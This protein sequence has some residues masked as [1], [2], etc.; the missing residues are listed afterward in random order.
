MQSIPATAPVDMVMPQTP[1]LVINIIS[2]AIVAVFLVMAI[3]HYRREG[4][5]IGIW[6]LLGGAFSVFNEPI[7]DVLGK[8]WFPAIDSWVL[9]SAWGVSIPHHMVPVYIWFVG[10]QAFL[11][12]RLFQKGVTRRRVFELYAMTAVV[13]VF[14]EVPG[15]QLDMYSYHGNQPFVFMKFPLWWTFCNSLM[16]LLLAALVYRIDYLL[17][18]V[19]RVLLVPLTWMVAAASNG[20]IAAPIWV[21]LNAEGSTML[22][23]H[24][25]AVFSFGLSLMVCYGVTLLAAKEGAPIGKSFARA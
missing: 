23:T 25:A 16:P 2:W 22:L 9:F 10:G 13:N 24:I 18:G 12:Y 17:T 1:Q 8:C 20:L 6:F 7:V 11:Y 4:S 5:S 21:A 3:K 15:L 19:R 14:L